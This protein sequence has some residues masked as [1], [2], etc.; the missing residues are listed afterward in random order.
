M[1]DFFQTGVIA[2]LH[3]LAEHD[4]DRF[5][6]ELSHPACRKV[7]LLLP[8]L[9]SDFRSAA[10]E[11]ILTELES[12]E[13][14]QNILLILGRATAEDFAGAETRLARLKAKSTILWLESPAATSLFELFNKNDLNIPSTGK[15]SAVWIGF[16]L[17]NAYDRDAVITIHDCDITTYKREIVDRLC[18]PV[19]SPDF[20]YEFSKGYYAR[21]SGQLNG[22]VVRLFFTPLIRVLERLIGRHPFLSF[23]DSF[24]YPLSGECALTTNLAR[25]I[26]IPGDWGLEV[27][28][29]SEVYRSCAPSRVCD[30]EIM[31]GFYDHKHQILTNE[32]G[33][34]GLRRMA[35]EIARTF[36]RTLAI[37]GIPLDD[38]LFRSLRIGYL[39][40]AQDYIHRYADDA[41]I[42]GIHYDRHVEGTA[43]DLFTS[44]LGDAIEQFRADPVG[45]PALPNWNRVASAIPDIYDR[46]LDATNRRAS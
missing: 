2:T 33:S 10:M 41:R 15:G 16:G 43:V 11:K 36:F 27:G 42:D 5:T 18:Y 45:T 13:Y 31:D 8:C 46:L 21:V 34:G 29:L 24:R 26:R 39:R 32:S 44:A 12:A 7:M 1:P 37:E 3:R 14:L 22:R 35:T 20:G 25:L 40:S 4:S 19:A 23:A 6:R 28:F 30:V 9:A 38:G 17:A